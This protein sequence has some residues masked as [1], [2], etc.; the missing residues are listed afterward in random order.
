[1]PKY[2]IVSSEIFPFEDEWIEEQGHDVIVTTGPGPV[3]TQ[4]IGSIFNQPGWKFWMHHADPY[5]QPEHG[6]W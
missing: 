1:M 3:H 2:V 5:S 4:V 6:R